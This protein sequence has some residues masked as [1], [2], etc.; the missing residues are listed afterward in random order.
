MLEECLDLQEPLLVVEVKKGCSSEELGPKQNGLCSVAIVSHMCGEGSVGLS[1]NLVELCPGEEAAG[2]DVGDA[3]VVDG[4]VE[5]GALS[6]GQ[7][8]SVENL[9]KLITLVL[10][11]LLLRGLPGC[12]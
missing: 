7:S 2:K 3:E 4:L 8:R 12:G 9:L 10:E 6:P 5:N 1:L 11:Y